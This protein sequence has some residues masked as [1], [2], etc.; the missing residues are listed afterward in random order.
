MPEI[1]K[2]PPV[3]CG[4]CPYRRDVPSGIWAPHEYDKLVAY[5]RPTMEQPGAVFLCH[6]RDGCIC[7]GWLACHPKRGPSG[8]LALRL[9]AMKGELDLGVLDYTTDVALFASGEEARRHGRRRITNPGTKA[10]K[11]VAG[12][13]RKMGAKS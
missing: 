6:Q 11:M 8:L 2:A 9:S 13:Q 7:G 12:L 4:S 1:L 10:R 3:P 5:D